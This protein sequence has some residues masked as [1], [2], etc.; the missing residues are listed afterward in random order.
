MSVV[1]MEGF[2]LATHFNECMSPPPPPPPCVFFFPFSLVWS[3]DHHCLRFLV[4]RVG[5]RGRGSPLFM[6]CFLTECGHIVV[7]GTKERGI[8]YKEERPPGAP[9]GPLIPLEGPPEGLP[10]PNLMIVYH[11][12]VAG[13]PRPRA[14]QASKGAREPPCKLY[15]SYMIPPAAYMGPIPKPR[16]G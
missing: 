2:D 16:R 3:R 9:P 5:V 6:K 12:P 10:M 14:I 1:D 7:H 13:G 8:A 11:W 4:E 15:L